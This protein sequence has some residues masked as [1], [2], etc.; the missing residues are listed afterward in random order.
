MKFFKVT[1]EVAE[2]VLKVLLVTPKSRLSKGD[3]SFGGRVLE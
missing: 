3:F 1:E 2:I